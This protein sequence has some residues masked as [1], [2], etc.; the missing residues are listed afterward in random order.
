M[1]HLGLAMVLCVT[2][3]GS[4]VFFECAESAQCGP[5][6]LCEVN[7]A[8]SFPDDTCESGRRYGQLGPPAIAGQCV[9]VGRDDD[10]TST[11]ASEGGTSLTSSH[12][13]T[14]ALGDDG[15]TGSTG[16][17]MTTSSTLDV[18]GPDDESDDTGEPTPTFFD[19]FERP[20]SVSLG[21]GWWEKT[22]AAFEIE[23]GHVTRVNTTN[24]YP[25]NLVLRPEDELLGDVEFAI[26]VD[27]LQVNPLGHPQLHG[28]VQL[29]DYKSSGSVTGYILFVTNGNTLQI[30]RQE[31]AV[32]ATSFDVALTDPLDVDATYRLRLVITGDDPVQLDGYFE[33]RGADTSWIP[34][35]E[36]HVTDSDP[37]RIA[38]PGLVGF[39]AHSEL[40]HFTYDD[41]WWTTP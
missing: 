11:G 21:N 23:S 2:G 3:C 17:S 29:G 41:F 15:S 25:N 28:R 38:E 22:P 27:P 12:S 4:D 10:A 26:N 39:S 18:T 7:G 30:T 16:S 5:D 31:A 34:H 20:D 19:D 1:R 36:I 24:G 37:T 32:F 35:T 40:E 6:G 33:E 13:D 14:L 9:P 8:C